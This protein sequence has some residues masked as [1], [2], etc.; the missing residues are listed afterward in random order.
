MCLVGLA[1]EDIGIFAIKF[2]TFLTGSIASGRILYSLMPATPTFFNT[3]FIF[4]I[5]A[6]FLGVWFLIS[7]KKLD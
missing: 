7:L 5:I 6:C 3:F 1:K 4:E 2:L